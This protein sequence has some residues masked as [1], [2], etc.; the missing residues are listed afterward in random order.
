M[1]SEAAGNQGGV[2]LACFALGDVTLAVELQQLR[3]VARC[4]TL[5]LLP[6]APSLIEGVVDLRGR[7][8]PVV[9]LGRALLDRPVADDPLARVAVIECDGLVLG[10]RVGNEAEVVTLPASALAEPPALATHAGYDAVRAVVRREGAPPALVISVEN[11]L[12]R[13]YRSA[14]PQEEE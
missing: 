4:P 12:E 7:V 14:R 3:E 9:D 10:L 11:L 6:K 1:Q 8:I 5:T 2:E 13:I